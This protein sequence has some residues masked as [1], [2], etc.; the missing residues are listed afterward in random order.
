MGSPLWDPGLLL[1]FL[2]CTARGTTRSGK[3]SDVNNE[4]QLVKINNT[5]ITAIPGQPSTSEGIF[6]TIQLYE[7]LAVTQSPLKSKTSLAF[8]TL[9]LAR[10]TYKAGTKIAESFS[11]VDSLKIMDTMDK[12]VT[13]AILEST[14]SAVPS[15]PIVSESGTVIGKN[16]SHTKTLKMAFSTT[17]AE[18]AKRE[19]LAQA[20]GWPGMRV[21]QKVVW[22]SLTESP[23]LPLPTHQSDYDSLQSVTGHPWTSP[24]NSGIPENYETSIKTPTFTEAMTTIDTFTESEI[25]NPFRTIVLEDT[26][27]IMIPPRTET[28]IVEEIIP[29][30]FLPTFTEIEDTTSNTIEREGT[31]VKTTTLPG[32]LTT[33]SSITEATMLTSNLTDTFLTADSTQ[34]ME[35]ST[36]VTL[37]MVYTNP[38]AET[39]TLEI[40]TSAETLGVTS[41]NSQSKTIGEETTLTTNITEMNGTR[42]KT[43]ILPGT[44]MTIDNS[45]E[46]ST[47]AFLKMNFFSETSASSSSAEEE[48]STDV[49]TLTMTNTITVALST[50]AETPNAVGI[51]D[52]TGQTVETTAKMATDTVNTVYV[53][54]TED[55]MAPTDTTVFTEV[56]SKVTISTED[57]STIAKFTSPAEFSDKVSTTTEG[58]TTPGINSSREKTLTTSKTP[59]IDSTI[60]KD[61][62]TTLRN[63]STEADSSHDEGFLLLRLVVSSTLDLTDDKVA[64]EFLNK[65]HQDLQEQVPYTQISLMKVTRS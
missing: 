21:F 43:T 49:E 61:T 34:E 2:H 53:P 52:T 18:M 10:T 30:T 60:G 35:T 6:G 41:N 65:L 55:T 17:E 23:L 7:T 44:S 40:D 14:N 16:H 42:A 64:K 59:A 27:E 37:P 22:K 5:E 62:A 11:P 45:T 33:V 25:P 19:S 48:L 63:Q 13:T 32:I 31:L 38:E 39:T 46:E 9:A 56:P 20:K 29:F 50:T 1:I 57:G 4:D 54:T 28:V 24:L 26:S 3:G 58:T 12:T 15:V 51:F 36:A 8:E 47:S